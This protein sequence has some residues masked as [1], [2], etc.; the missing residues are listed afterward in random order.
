MTKIFAVYDN[1]AEAFMQPFFAETVG[2]ALRAFQQNT[3]NPDS[4]L[5][6]Y[7]N[8]FVLYEIGTFDDITGSLNNYE[9]NKN[10]G[11]AIEYHPN[12][13]LRGVENG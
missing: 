7:P 2:L 13:E 3:E 5:Y 6:K 4:V 1:K 10:L 12:K 11:M 8:D 9:Q